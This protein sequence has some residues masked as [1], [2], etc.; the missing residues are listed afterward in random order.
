MNTLYLCPV[1]QDRVDVGA[2]QTVADSS[3]LIVIMCPNTL[4]Y[5]QNTPAE[6]RLHFLPL[7]S[8]KSDVTPQI[9]TI[10]W[11]QFAELSKQFSKIITWYL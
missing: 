3:D 4:P 7:R 9:K 10:N 6:T 2:L 5:L 1:N 11:P 8:P